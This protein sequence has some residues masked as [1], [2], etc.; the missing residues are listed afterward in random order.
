MS[1]VS[2]MW[3]VFNNATYFNGDISKWDMSNVSKMLLMFYRY[4]NWDFNGD[5]SKWYVSRVSDTSYI[6]YGAESF[7]SDMSK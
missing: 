1:R 4:N 2:D 3:G 7:N 5:I 6:F